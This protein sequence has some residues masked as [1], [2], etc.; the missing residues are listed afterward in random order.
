M[1]K[2]RSWSEVRATATASGLIDEKDVDEARAQ[3]HDM[4]RAQRLADIRKRHSI[5]QSGL[6]KRMK[7]SQAR[8]SKIENGDLSHTEL[9]TLESYVEALG[10]KL[11]IVADFGD[12]AIE[13]H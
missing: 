13:V 1:A 12:S 4:V 8:V 6:S 9:G 7:I 2:A 3:L 5:S 10:G 11:R